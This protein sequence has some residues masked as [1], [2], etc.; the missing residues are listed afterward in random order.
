MLV[1]NTSR[2]TQNIFYPFLKNAI[3]SAIYNLLSAD[4]VKSIGSKILVK[5]KGV[6]SVIRQS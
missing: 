6:L 4:A 5:G 3:R 1:N 2:F